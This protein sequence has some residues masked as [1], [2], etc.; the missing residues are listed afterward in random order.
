VAR[1]I[2]AAYKSM[3]MGRVRPL[4]TLRPVYLL[5]LSAVV[6]TLWLSMI[7]VLGVGP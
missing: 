5:T 1:S 4:M 2:K 7:A 6:R 3:R